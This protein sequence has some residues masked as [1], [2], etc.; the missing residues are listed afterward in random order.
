MP[1]GVIYQYLSTSDNNKEFTVDF[2]FVLNQNEIIVSVASYHF[3]TRYE[4]LRQKH[5]NISSTFRGVF[6]TIIEL[7]ENEL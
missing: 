3:E 7:L 6:D 5:I 2:K 4:C 1:A